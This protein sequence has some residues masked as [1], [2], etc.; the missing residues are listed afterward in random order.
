MLLN[1]TTYINAKNSVFALNNTPPYTDLT[2]KN[3]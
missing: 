1:P 3:R 2:K